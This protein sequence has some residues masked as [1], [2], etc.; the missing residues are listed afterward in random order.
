MLVVQ[1]MRVEVFQKKSF[2]STTQNLC[3]NFRINLKTI[4]TQISKPLMINTKQKMKIIR[5]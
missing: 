5:F 1:L 2:S 4:M 3:L